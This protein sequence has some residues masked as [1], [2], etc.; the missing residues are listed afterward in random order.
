MPVLLLFTVF[1]I[2]IIVSVLKTGGEGTVD[3]PPLKLANGMLRPYR[4][5]FTLGLQIF[6]YLKSWSVSNDTIQSNQKRLSAVTTVQYRPLLL[7][8]RW[9]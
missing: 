9:P 7:M 3:N 8:T 6:D 2:V 5:P 4:S 1:I